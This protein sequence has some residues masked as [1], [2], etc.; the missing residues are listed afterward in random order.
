MSS[1]RISPR[2]YRDLEIC[3]AAMLAVLYGIAWFAPAIGLA[4]RD[5]VNLASAE[6]FG[7]ARHLDPPL[8]PALLALFAMVSRQAQWLKLAPLLCTLLWLG[9]T[10]RLLG[11]M[12]AS[13]E[14]AWMLV[15]MTAASPTVLYLAT[16][17]FAEPL[18][19]L[20]V[21]ACLLALL[22][23]KALLAGL[24]AGLATI[25]LSVGVSLILACLVTLV[26]TGRLRSAAKFTGTAI[27]FAAPWLGWSLAH[28]GVPAAN[29]HLSELAVLTGK[30]AMLLAA[31]PF[32]LLTGWQ[33]LYP[34]LLTAVALLIVLIRR[35]FFVPDLFI[36]FYSAMLI[37]RTE[38][39]LDA[40]APV[41]P[42]FLWMLWRVARTGRFATVAK[43]A[44]VLMILPALWF[45]ASR[46]ATVPSLGAVTGD[47]V[48]GGTVRPDNWHEMETLFTF[49]R[50]YTP[51]DAVLLAELD[52]VFQVNTGRRTVHGFVRDGYRN[53]YGPPGSLVTPDQ[54]RS[55]MFRENVAYVALTPDRDLPE[56]AS[57][58]KA[59]A[60]LERGGV[61]EPLSVYGVTGEYRLLRVAR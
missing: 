4:Y 18:F 41:L 13:A 39:P 48:D 17:L 40:F 21:T 15:L 23:D 20:L 7:S 44:A 2:L 36:G 14:C 54:L 60:A 12:G 42:L 22:D 9:L 1:L 55:A 45:G 10:K 43:A 25:T 50:A 27:I 57:F 6:A 16:G 3:L 35:R 11:K 58:Q 56:W 32:T 29:L 28:G 33:N 24:F 47:P 59:V 26:A 30:N 31:S 5:G 52:P 38:S 51:A 19:G 61:L 49:I 8:F 37:W 34:G 46:V 53:S